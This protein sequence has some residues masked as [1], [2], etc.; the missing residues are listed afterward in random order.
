M[1]VITNNLRAVA[2]YWWVLLAGTV[3]PFL[4]IFKFLHPKNREFRLHPSLRIGIAALAIVIAEVLA[5]RDQG[6]NLS[7]VI[8]EKQQLSIENNTLNEELKAKINEN[9]KLKAYVPS[10]DSLKVRAVTKAEE[11]EKF[12]GQ[13]A[14]HEPKCTQTS[15]MTPEQQQAVIAPCAKYNMETMRLYS[16]LF[17]PD[18]M[19]MVAE[20]KSKGID[21]MNIENCA[22]QGLCGIVISVQLR[23][24]AARLDASDKV[25]R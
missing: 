22:P 2:S 21:V 12:F 6:K 15:K 8:G 16:Q 10:E 25:K 11:L 13:R 7:N 19:A 3:M 20:F 23:A 4:D 9:A 5:Y 18:I 17:A 24:F 14:K 1:G